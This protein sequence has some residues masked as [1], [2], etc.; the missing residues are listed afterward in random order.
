[1]ADLRCGHGVGHPDPL[2][3]AGVIGSQGLFL[4]LTWR[5]HWRGYL[6]WAGTLIVIFLLYAP[7]LFFGSALL[8]RFLHWLKQ[9]TL[10]ETYL[11]GAQAY[12]VGE[13]MPLAEAVPLVLVFVAVYA[14]GLI[15]AT[16][17]SLGYLARLGNAGLSPGLHDC[18]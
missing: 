6:A 2:P 9:P 17:R 11:R 10:W 14:L 3:C 12:T 15:Y 7:W 1:M 5:R 8:Q 16:R 13:Y 4:L 18:P